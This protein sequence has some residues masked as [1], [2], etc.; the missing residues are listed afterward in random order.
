MIAYLFE[1]VINSERMIV[2]LDS[3]LDDPLGQMHV[4]I[5][6]IHHRICQKRINHSLEVA[7]ASPGCLGN[8]SYYILGNLQSVATTLV[9]EDIHAQLHIRFLHL[10]NKT[11]R[12]SSEQTVLHALKVNWRTV[13]GKDNLLAVAEEMIEDMEEGVEGAGGC[14]P[15][16][17]IIHDEHVDALIEIDEVVDS[18]LQQGV[19]ELHLEETGTDIEYSLMGIE[20]L[21]PHA[22]GI[23]KVGLAAS[24]GPYI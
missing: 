17:D 3:T 12:E 6:I 13:T 8:I 7:H 1:D 14:G 10:S 21:A 18:F 16:L 11:A 9:L 24:R 19:G 20:F 4:N 22:D 15:L 23:D 2:H 5:A